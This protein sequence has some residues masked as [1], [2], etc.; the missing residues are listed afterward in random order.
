MTA[1]YSPELSGVF[2]YFDGEKTEAKPDLFAGTAASY[3][4]ENK[5][6][7]LILLDEI[8]GVELLDPEF[9]KA[10]YA[11]LEGDIS[12]LGVLKLEAS[13][14]NMCQNRAIDSGCVDYHLKLREDLTRRFGADIVRFERART[15]DAERILDEFIHTIFGESGV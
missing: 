15:R 14:R 9:R 8:G 1:E 3:L 4:R 12:C 10:L 7:K 11:A 5:G 6:K 2:L 13:M